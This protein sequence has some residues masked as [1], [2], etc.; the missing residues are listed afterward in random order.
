M[1]QTEL[2]ES[3]EIIQNEIPFI[4]KKPYS[5]NI[6]TAQ[7]QLIDKIFGKDTV[8]KVIIDNHLRCYGWRTVP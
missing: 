4:D 6:I 5:H 7:L 2:H 8:N 1:D 3:I